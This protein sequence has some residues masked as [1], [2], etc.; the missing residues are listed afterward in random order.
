MRAS[1]KAAADPTVRQMIA[2]GGSPVEYLDAPEFQ[3]YWTPTP[4]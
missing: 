3:A 1:A 2:Q 4:R